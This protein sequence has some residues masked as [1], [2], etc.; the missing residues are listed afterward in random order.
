VIVLRKCAN[1]SSVPVF[2]RSGQFVQDPWHAGGI[3]EESVDVE[4]AVVWDF[5]EADVVC[6]YPSSVNVAKRLFQNVVLSLCWV[7]SCMDALG[8][9]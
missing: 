4:E 8:Q 7:P 6:Q 5:E 1:T 2:L 9:N 3:L